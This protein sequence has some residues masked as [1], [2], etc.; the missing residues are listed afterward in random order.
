MLQKIRRSGLLA[1]IGAVL[2]TGVV[3]AA[4]MF[5]QAKANEFDPGKT[6]LVQAAWLS[7][8]GCPTNAQFLDYGTN[9]KMPY[10]DTACP[11]GDSSDRTNEGLVLAK[12]GPTANYAAAG[13]DLKDVKGMALTELGYDIRKPMSTSDPRGSHCGAGAPRFDIQIG[14]AWYAIGCN[15]PTPVQTASS[16]GWLRLRW[17]GAVPLMAFSYDTGLL[18]DISGQKV[19]QIQ[20]VFDEGQDAG[21]DN[22]GLAVIDNVDVNGVLVGQGSPDPN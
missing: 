1:A 15:S 12:T 18:T 7:G 13:A 19:N 21:P 16:T 20:I 5:H 6:F 9:T 2:V 11:V 3:I 8:L 14:T 22:F 17:G 10:S 4:P